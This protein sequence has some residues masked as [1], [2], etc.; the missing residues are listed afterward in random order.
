MD[1][2]TGPRR[3]RVRATVDVAN[4]HRFYQ[5]E[6]S[7]ESDL[8]VGGLGVEQQDQRLV[9]MSQSDVAESGV[10]MITHPR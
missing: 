4:E 5:T 2:K 7:Q 9:S 6:A 10:G 8:G 3:P 1:K